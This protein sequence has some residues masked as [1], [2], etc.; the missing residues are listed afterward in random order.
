MKKPQ[1]TEAFYFI[2]IFL[3]LF[4]AVMALR[5]HAVIPHR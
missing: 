2:E 5:I 4:N 1:I 3:K